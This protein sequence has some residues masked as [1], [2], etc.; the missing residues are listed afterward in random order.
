MPEHSNSGR[1]TAE[2]SSL[3]D[4]EELEAL[5]DD[6]KAVGEPDE[7]IANVS[8]VAA[9]DREF[10]ADIRELYRRK[11]MHEE[12]IGRPFATPYPAYLGEFMLGADPDERPV[13]VTRQQLNEHML[14]V[15]RS[16]AGKT[17]FF[18]NM[19]SLLD[20]VD[21]PFLVFDFKNDYRHVV[22]EFDLTVINWQDLKFNPLQ[23]PPGVR[24]EQ[25]GEVLA[26]T[27]SHAV[28]LLNASRN[29][30]LGNLRVLYNLYDEQMADGAYPSLFELRDVV[31]AQ[32]I[33]YASP[34][35]R[36]KERVENRLTG[37]LG[38][39]GDI[40]ECSTGFPIE[41]LLDRNV[42]V[43][44]QEPNQDVQ[45]FM[46]EVL[47]TWLFYYRDAQ[48]HR[49]G[50][51]HAVL[52]DEAKQVFDVHR[53]QNVDTPQPPITSLM[54]RVR[55]FGEA[56]VVADHEPSKLSDSLKANT[57]L[58][59]W[60][61]LGSGHDTQEMAETFGIEDD[62]VGFTRTLE[63]G[64][65][66]VKAA[67]CDPVPVRLPPYFVE[68]STTEEVVRE[69]MQS[70]LDELAYG[71]RV[72]PDRFLEVVGRHW[73]TTDATDDTDAETDEDGGAV[74]DVAEAVLAS[75]NDQPFLSMSQR[76]DAVDVG[77]K[78]GNEAKNQLVALELVREVEVDT[79]KPGRNPKLLELTEAGKEV[80]AERGY[81][82]VATGRRGVV[83]RYW[84][85]QI[86]EYYE[87]DGFSVEIESAVSDG[88]VD[89]YAETTGEVVAVEVARSP[90]HE[91]ANV[92]KCLGLDVDRVEVATLEEGVRERIEAAVR[93][94]FDGVPDQVV[95]VDVAEYV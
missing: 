27:W 72:R 32:E 70:V 29:H 18:Y 11:R 1:S 60:M 33:P 77:A 53:E 23:P 74:G 71:E 15:G 13:C 62:E 58:K 47:L 39:G 63:R 22:D 75:V 90:E 44:L 46:V 67:S 41:E 91:V 30:F 78:T 73:E 12:P 20:G 3:T 9:V 51:R 19:M 40:F 37:M 4:Q 94:E 66:V 7:K 28:G 38:F 61:S 55:E 34:R 82:V 84:Q 25:W 86:K 95:F 88:F 24:I 79:R 6:M 92:R 16:G 65:A 57:N 35:Y 42:V 45:T 31:A 89:V 36:Y 21:I 52:F 14:V 85:Q 76:Y 68:K 93:D 49:D 48:G 80:L 56:L 26:D 2:R 10:F 50:L 69:R 81:D 83:H 54:G 43:E 8:R 17:T 64:E 87:A 5:Q 59:V